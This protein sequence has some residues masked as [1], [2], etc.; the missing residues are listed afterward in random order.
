MTGLSI[1]DMRPEDEY[2][3]SFYHKVGS[4]DS[5]HDV[6]LVRHTETGNIYVRKES[7]DYDLSVFH[8]LYENHYDGVPEIIEYAEDPD[9]HRL[10]VIEE[11]INGRTLRTILDHKRTLPVDQAVSVL[12]AIC[13]TLEPLHAHEPP[14]IH[15]DIKPENILITSKSVLYLVDFDASKSYSAGKDRDTELI[16]TR[17]YAAPEQYG[18]SQSDPRTDIYAIGKIGLEMIYGDPTIKPGKK[19]DPVDSILRKCTSMDPDDRFNSVKELREALINLDNPGLFNRY[20]R[21]ALPGFRTH[22]FW[23]MLL[24]TIFYCYLIVTVIYNSINTDLS[25]KDRIVSGIGFMADM[26]LLILFYFNYMG[27]HSHLPLMKS[28]SIPIRAVGY[29][30]YTLAIITAVS[31]V[32]AFFGYTYTA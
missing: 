17:K 6:D 9:A 23:K 21:M 10:I 20:S 2:K 7:A 27:C 5:A 22:T 12:K 3:L 14:I 18:F 24:A 8:A 4:L 31:M 29:I 13:E 30:V 19:N 16:G 11:F 26:M 25:I 28:K 1:A 15:R 32:M